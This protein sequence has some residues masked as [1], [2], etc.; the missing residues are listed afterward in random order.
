MTVSPQPSLQPGAPGASGAAAELVEAQRQIT[1]LNR[2]LERERR[3]REEAEGIADR[4]MR[5][6][7]LSNQELDERVAE[8]TKSITAAY[9]LLE[10]SF[11]AATRFVSN[12]SH[13][14][15]TPLNGVFGMLELIEQHAHTDI[16]ANYVDTA[17]S[18][19]ERLHLLV[20]RLLDLVQLSA[21][22][23]QAS[24]VEFGV[25]DLV[26][27]IEQR[28]RVKFLQAQKLLTLSHSIDAGHVLNADV[29]RTLQIV[30]E[31]LDNARLH[32]DPGVVDVTMSIVDHDD[33]EP[34]LRIVVTDAGPGFAPAD[35]SGI[36][37][38]ILQVDTSPG[39]AT[40][41]AGIGLGLAM[42]LARA[43]GGTVNIDSAPGSPTVV[44]ITLPV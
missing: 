7:W 6:L 39:R 8:Q 3:A 27:P 34:S 4:R 14:M 22:L 35:T 12:L 29:E 19:T 42:E 28:W 26:G 41:G 2:R 20:R 11:G 40:E 10:R 44:S 24:P 30:D 5:E 18:S 43:V 13:E 36:F 32:A 15:L 37:D 25:A 23:L 31:I 21:G 38:A 9:D 17:R 33:A 16:L 1:R